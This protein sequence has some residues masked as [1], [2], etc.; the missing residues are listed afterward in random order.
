MTQSETV[1]ISAVLSFAST[2]CSVSRLSLTWASRSYARRTR[3]S[4]KTPTRSQTR[5]YNDSS[6]PYACS[7]FLL[8]HLLCFRCA[9]YYYSHSASSSFEQACISSKHLIFPFSF[10]YLL[11]RQSEFGLPNFRS[12]SPADKRCISYTS[13]P[14]N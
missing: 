12:L 4:F 13:L 14:Y 11:G 8:L 2:N 3:R 9:P 7:C 1:E 6:R 10:R 5:T